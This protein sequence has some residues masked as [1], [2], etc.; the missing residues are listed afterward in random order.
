MMYFLSALFGLGVYAQYVQI[1]LAVEPIPGFEVGQIE[2][3]F[4]P[5]TLVFQIC[6]MGFL[7]HTLRTLR[8]GTMRP[9]RWK[10]RACFIL[11]GPYLALM[12]LRY[13]AELSILA[14]G[15]SFSKALPLFLHVVLGAFVLLLGLHTYFGFRNRRLFRPARH[16]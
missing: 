14:E 10:Y 13:S 1:A 6:V 5:I 12:L 8:K 7:I 11:G 15:G 4:R 3:L 2:N 16:F 9:R